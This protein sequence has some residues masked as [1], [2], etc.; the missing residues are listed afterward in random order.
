MEKEVTTIIMTKKARLIFILLSL[1]LL[2]SWGKI[3]AQQWS[4]SSPDKKITINVSNRDKASYSVSYDKHIVIKESPLGILRDDQQFSSSL[5]F[6]EKKENQIKD[7]Y[8]LLVGKKLQVK[9]QANEL[10]LTFENDKAEKINFIFRAY[11]D[12]IAFR[13]H[14]PKTDAGTHK[15]TQEITGFA[16]P[17]EARSWIQPYDL[18]VRKKPCYETYYEDAVTP[19]S[20]SPNPAGWAFPALFN[21]GEI[22]MLISEA[23]LDETY[24]ATHLED[25]Q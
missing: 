18:N 15:I 7:A 13:Y 23:A 8:T 19:G 12:G 14:F 3:R 21:L 5:R 16:I 24:C 11:N 20:P 10:V 1:T 22:W 6:I 2:V 9:N 25:K 4:I 17:G